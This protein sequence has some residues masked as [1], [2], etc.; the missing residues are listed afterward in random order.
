MATDETTPDATREGPGGTPEG[1]TPE[2]PAPDE[3]GK[4][5]APYA[6]LSPEAPHRADAEDAERTDEDL[7]AADAHHV[8]GGHEHEHMA[9]GHAHEDDHSEDHGEE[10]LGPVDWGAWGAS[11]VGIGAGALVALAMFVGI[12]RG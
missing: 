11:L 8:G 3:L 5:G 9:A 2:R 4:P 1:H 7:H 12:A 6:E 10:P